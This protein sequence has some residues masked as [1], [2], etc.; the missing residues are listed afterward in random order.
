MRLSSRLIGMG[1][2]MV[3]SQAGSADGR[4]GQAM[5]A[6]VEALAEEM[7]S[8]QVGSAYQLA[9]QERQHAQQLR[10]KESD[11]QDARV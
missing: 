11:A 2:A 1:D 5:E 10:Q 7:R 9:F 4:G 6:R 8:Q 3:V